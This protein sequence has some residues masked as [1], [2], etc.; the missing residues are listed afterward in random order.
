MRDLVITLVHIAAFIGGVLIV[1]RTVMSAIR[2][3]VLARSARDPIFAWV[4]VTI[5]R[6][7]TWRVKRFQTVDHTRPPH[8]YLRRRN[9][10]TTFR[11]HLF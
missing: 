10:R 7:Y 1:V 8:S 6:L 5:R 4:F 11:H 2:T 3:P 9:A